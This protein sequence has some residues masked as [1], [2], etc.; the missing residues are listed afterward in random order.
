MAPGSISAVTV[1]L[2][3]I[4]TFVFSFVLLTDKVPGIPQDTSGLNLEQGFYDLHQVCVVAIGL[5]N[6]SNK[7]GTRL[8]PA[9][10]RSIRM[11]MA[12][13]VLTSCPGSATSRLAI[14]MSTLTTTGRPTRPGQREHRPSV[15]RETISLSKSMVRILSFWIKEVLSCALLLLYCSRLD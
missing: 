6:V 7:A 14:H 15:L 8:P 10:I 12:L 9:L 3:I 5:Q 11:Q 1:S 2:I 4:Y 13:S